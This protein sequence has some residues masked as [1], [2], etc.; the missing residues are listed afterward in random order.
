M[1]AMPLPRFLAQTAILVVFCAPLLLGGCSGIDGIDLNG[2]V[3]DWLGVSSASQVKEEPQMADRAPL[4]VPPSVTRLPEPGSGQV[5]SQEL[6]ALKDP[7]HEKKAKA[8]ERQRLHEAYCR[9]EIQWKDK[10]FKPQDNAGAPRSP[11]GTCGLFGAATS[12]I[13][14]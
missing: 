14:K 10:A 5:S 13:T 4:V 3:F 11:Y 9:G 7:E 2:K 8:A 12:N 1:L 6:A